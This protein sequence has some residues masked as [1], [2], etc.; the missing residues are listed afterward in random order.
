[1]DVNG[2]SYP[3]IIIGGHHPVP[4]CVVLGDVGPHGLYG[5]MVI[6]LVI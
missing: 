5:S 4:P 1:M 2:G 6:E 3:T